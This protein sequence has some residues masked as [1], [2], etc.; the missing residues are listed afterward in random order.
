MLRKARRNADKSGL[1]NVSFVSSKITDIFLPDS[2]ADVIISNCVINLVPHSE[3]PQVFHEIFRLLNPGGRVAI[4]DILIKKE[5]T[6]QMKKDVALYVGCI[7]GASKKEDY[8]Q[9]LNDA[10][11]SDIF[12]VDT[13]SDLN[14]YNQTS[15]DGRVLGRMCCGSSSDESSCGEEGN[16]GSEVQIRT[17]CCGT[18][19]NGSHVEDKDVIAAM[20]TNFGGVNLNDW[21]GK[22]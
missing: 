10:G 18:G 6:E 17:T 22:F 16:K 8:K 13:G 1:Q 9:W 14:I 2:T 11:F 7:A 3:K 21:A 5:L 19:D 15:E 4:S 12:I 20:K